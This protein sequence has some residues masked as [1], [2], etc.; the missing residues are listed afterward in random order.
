MTVETALVLP[1]TFMILVGL[2][3]LT[4]AVFR[5]QQ[6]AFLAREAA[7]YAAVHGGQYR[8]QNAAAIAAGTLPDATADYIAANLVKARSAAMDPAGIQVVI[9][10][11]TSGGSYDW[12]DTANNGDRWPNSPRTING[13]TYQET[14]TVSVTVT[15]TWI[16]EWFM[17]GPMTVTST[18]VVP[19]CY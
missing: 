15:Y 5:Y 6:V 4:V 18:A 7:R 12:D 3:V 10:F 13:T 19:V 8:Q 17:S 16:P 14:N 9:R 11:N 1:I 2:V